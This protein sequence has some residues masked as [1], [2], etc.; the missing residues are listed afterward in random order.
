VLSHAAL[1]A[2]LIANR[3][4]DLCIRM[5]RQDSLTS[6][7][8][9]VCRPMQCPQADQVKRGARCQTAGHCV[10]SGLS[11]RGA[12]MPTRRLVNGFGGVEF[13]RFEVKHC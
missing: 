11:D 3:D 13:P 4:A 9:G 1:T 6:A 7:D 12:Y 2:L 8:S 10:G 5:R